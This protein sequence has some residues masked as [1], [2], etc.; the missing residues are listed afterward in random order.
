MPKSAERA[1]MLGRVGEW[2]QLMVIP[3]LSTWP[4]LSLLVQRLS[5]TGRLIGR[6]SA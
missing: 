2:H 3:V 1:Q 6:Q 4:K 5:V